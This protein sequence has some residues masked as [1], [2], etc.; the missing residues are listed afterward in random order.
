[1]KTRCFPAISQVFDNDLPKQKAL[2]APSC[3]RHRIR[4]SFCSSIVA[5]SSDQQQKK[6]H[7][8]KKIN[9]GWLKE[10]YARELIHDYLPEMEVLP[11][12]ANADLL[13]ICLGRYTV[14]CKIRFLIWRKESF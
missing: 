11:N 7:D 4:S 13:I 6:Y 12:P 3:L 8:C 9:R 14:S 5:L 1:M 10:G 2:P